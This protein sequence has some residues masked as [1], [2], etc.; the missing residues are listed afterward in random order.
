MESR[1]LEPQENSVLE[2]LNS[3][4]FVP[5][6]KFAAELKVSALRCYTVYTDGNEDSLLPYTIPDKVLTLIQCY[7]LPR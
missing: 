6:T 3:E 4:E 2:K 7:S 1:F 5:P